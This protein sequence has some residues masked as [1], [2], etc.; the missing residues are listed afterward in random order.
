MY[1]VYTGTNKKHECTVENE[2]GDVIVTFKGEFEPGTNGFC[3]Y[4]DSGKLLGDYTEYT[5]II[6][7]K[8]DGFTFSKTAKPEDSSTVEEKTLGQKLEETQREVEQLKEQLKI[9]T[10]ALEELKSETLKTEEENE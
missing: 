4:M 5:N 7:S 1:L 10:A 2:N 8:V 3:L 9:T 6:E